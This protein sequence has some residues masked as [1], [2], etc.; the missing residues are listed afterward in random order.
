MKSPLRATRKIWPLRPGKYPRANASSHASRAD[1]PGFGAVAGRCGVVLRQPIAP[2]RT[3]SN[4]HR[5]R[6]GACDNARTS[7][8]FSSVFINRARIATM[9][10]VRRVV[11]TAVAMMLLVAAAAFAQGQSSERPTQSLTVRPG[12]DAATEF[13]ARV[14]TYADLRAQLESGLPIRVVT[15]D[16][17]AIRSA[18]HTLATRIRAARAGAQEGDLFTPAVAEAIKQLLVSKV[19]PYTCLGIVDD[20]PGEFTHHVN[21]DY[22]D[23]RSLSTVP[24]N[25]L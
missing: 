13:A 15:T 11:S 14:Q 22:P 6:M 25:V 24:P 12:R 1:A 17:A 4:R 8:M 19:S 3:T 5:R 2:L 9:R 21:D 16:S 23:A 10:P 7:T 18:V 20:N